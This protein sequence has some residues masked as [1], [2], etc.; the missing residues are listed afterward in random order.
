VFC[1]FIGGCGRFF[2]SK[3]ESDIALPTY[4]KTPTELPAC[5][6]GLVLKVNEDSISSEEIISATEGQLKP[7]AK[8]AS[9]EEFRQRSVPMLNQVVMNKVTNSII[10]QM[11]KKNAPANI[12]EAVKKAADSEVRRFVSGFKGNYAEAENALKEMG[13]DWE[14]FHDYQKK[15]ILTQSYVSGELDD[16]QQIAHS[17][18]RDYYDKV[19]DQAFAIKPKVRFSLIDI[20]PKKQTVEDV[21][22]NSAEQLSLRAKEKAEEV[23]GKIRNGEDFAEVAKNYSNG[24][25]SSVGG[26]W[27]PVVP[28]S[29]ASPYDILEKKSLELDIGEVAG[30]IEVKDH[31]FILKLEDKQSESYVPFEEVQQ[32]IETRVKMERRKLAFEKMMAKLMDKADIGNLEEF[33]KYCVT[34][35]YYQ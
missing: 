13:M 27:S 25:R 9:F 11:A 10:Y 29:L 2:G 22:A 35:I 8:G 32:Q 5:S 14:S 26:L 18:L 24:F 34:K 3:S 28:G 4:Y 21:N 12:D 7:L 33:L 6:G 1:V 20:Q 31:I 17:V 15:L 23:M 16:D 30:P 19:K